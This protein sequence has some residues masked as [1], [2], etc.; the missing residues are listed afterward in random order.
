MIMAE[1]MIT[2]RIGTSGTSGVLK[3]RGVF[4]LFKAYGNVALGA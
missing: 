3:G 1:Q 2:A 4:G